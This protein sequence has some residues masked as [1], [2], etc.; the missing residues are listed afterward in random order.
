MRVAK[1]VSTKAY[2]AL[3]LN[4]IKEKSLESLNMTHDF[5]FKYNLCD[6]RSSYAEKSGHSFLKHDYHI[7][8]NA[9]CIVTIHKWS[10]VITDRA[11]TQS[12]GAALLQ[13][14]YGNFGLRLYYCLKADSFFFFLFF[15]F[16][17]HHLLLGTHKFIL[18]KD[19]VFCSE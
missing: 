11:R 8:K 17:L 2:M 4:S 10:M 9:H 18:F 7:L 15:F 19:Q 14:T 12:Y 3:V 5:G 13:A 6:Q 1:W 16:F